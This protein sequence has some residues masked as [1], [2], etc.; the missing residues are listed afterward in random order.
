MDNPEE[1]EEMKMPT[2]TFECPDGSR[3]T[4]RLSMSDYEAIKVGEK[5]IV[6]DEDNELKLVFNP[7]QVAFTLKDG[8][9]GGWPS[10]VNRERKYRTRRYKEMGKRQDDHAPKTRLVPNF[11]GKLADKWSDV[12]DHVRTEK[13]EVAAM[14]Y[15]RLV[16]RERQG[17]SR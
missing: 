9:S 14:T 4:K 3:F 8:E 15:D 2:Y 11:G 5:A 13:G 6:D 12:Q 16:S 10:R 1:K 17:V 7:G